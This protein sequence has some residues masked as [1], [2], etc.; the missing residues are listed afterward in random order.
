MR[1]TASIAATTPSAPS[2]RPPR[3]TVSRCEPDHDV[4]RRPTPGV[5]EEVAV[6]VDLDLE[7]GGLAATT[8]RAGAPRPL[9]RRGADGSR[10]GHRRSRTARRAARESAST[11]P[12][13]RAA[14]AAPAARRAARARPTGT[15][16]PTTSRTQSRRT[17]SAR[18]SRS[19]DSTDCWKPI[20]AP[21]RAGPASSAAAVNARA[22]QPMERPPATASAGTSSHSGPP[23]S[24]ATTPR[25][26]ATT[27]PTCRSGPMREPTTSDQRPVPIRIPTASTCAAAIT[28]AASRS[29]SPCSS[30]RNTT[31]NPMIAICA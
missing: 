11:E 8:R 5:P 17:R 20:A 15:R 14:A 1:S 16:A 21:L 3:G 13:G 7:P 24:K 6:P 10:R 22:F 28:S 2:N 19:P 29:E 12:R 27:T 31:P 23:A 4:S 18:R 26:M 25:L 9:P 30:W